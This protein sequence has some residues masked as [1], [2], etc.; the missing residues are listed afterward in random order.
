V[1]VELGDGLGASHGQQVPAAHP[2]SD[3]QP[4]ERLLADRHDV[5]GLIGE[6][7]AR[8]R[9]LFSIPGDTIRYTTAI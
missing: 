9:I 6:V 1:R 4:I 7:V 8:V 3:T 5:A 2:P